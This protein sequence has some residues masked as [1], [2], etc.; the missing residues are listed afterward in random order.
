MCIFTRRFW[1]MHLV[2]LLF[3]HAAPLTSLWCALNALCSHALTTNGL[4]HLHPSSS[5]K[6]EQAVLD[7]RAGHEAAMAAADAPRCE[8]SQHPYPAMRAAEVLMFSRSGN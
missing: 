4:P 2:Y 1:Q 6:F 3:S 8:E 5:K 7:F